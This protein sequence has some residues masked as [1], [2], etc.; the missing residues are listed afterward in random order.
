MTT[1]VRKILIAALLGAGVVFSPPA[2]ADVDLSFGIYAPDRRVKM[3]WQCP[4][5]VDAMEARMSRVLDEPV[6]IDVEINQSYDDGVDD[7]I[8]GLVD[9]ARFPNVDQGWVIHPDV[10]EPV[11]EAWRRAFASL[12][13]ER[14]PLLLN[15]NLFVEGGQGHCYE[16]ERLAASERTLGALQ[17]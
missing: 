11:I 6:A 10:P 4:A 5:L 9:F 16:L 7:V 1:R 14:L 3:I 8:A 2:L 12:N 15:P 17:F 13:L